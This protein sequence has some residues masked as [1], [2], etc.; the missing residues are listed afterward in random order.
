MVMQLALNLKVYLP[1]LNIN[2]LYLA[3]ALNNICFYVPNKDLEKQ[4]QILLFTTDFEALK[5]EVDHTIINFLLSWPGIVWVLS[6]AS[7]KLSPELPNYK[8]IGQTYNSIMESHK[9]QLENFHLNT[10]EDITKHYGP[11]LSLTAMGL[12]VLNWP[13]ILLDKGSLNL[14]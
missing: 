5:T 11:G 8:L 14:K 7:M 12:L 3:V 9:D 6:I 10:P 13:E 1:S 2:R 4:I